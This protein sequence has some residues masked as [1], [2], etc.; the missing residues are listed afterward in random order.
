[1]LVCAQDVPC[2]LGLTGSVLLLALLQGFAGGSDG[3]ES[4]CNS[5]DLG[6]IPG[7]G[8]F[9][10]EGNGNPLQ[11]SSLANCMDRGAWWATAHGGPRELNL[12]ERLTFS[13]FIFRPNAQERGGHSS[14]DVGTPLSGMHN[15]PGTAWGGHM[16]GERQ[17][18]SSGILMEEEALLSG[19]LGH[20]NDLHNT[21]LTAELQGGCRGAAV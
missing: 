15:C 10:G 12:T 7:L 6:S 13:L 11:Y 16:P 20:C 17:G 4:A 21:V 1:M 19:T 14:L 18:A 5:G 9:P 8:R 2:S 3:K